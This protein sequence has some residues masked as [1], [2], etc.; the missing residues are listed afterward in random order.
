[1]NKIA[2]YTLYT[3]QITLNIM[4]VGPLLLRIPS[5][6][7]DKAKFH[8]PVPQRTSPL[9]RA[10]DSVVRNSCREAV[11]YCYTNARF[12]SDPILCYIMGVAL[13]TPVRGC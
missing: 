4:K 10:N 8:N 9:M 5:A 13:V 12:V 1:M 2:A 7:F 11:S 6:T 3:I